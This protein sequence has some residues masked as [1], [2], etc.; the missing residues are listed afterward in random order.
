MGHVRG[1]DGRT[2]PEL[3]PP[4]HEAG[5]VI[6][7][8]VNV[9]TPVPPGPLHLLKPFCDVVMR[10]ASSM[11]PD[12]PGEN[13]RPLHLRPPRDVTL[14]TLGRQQVL[15]PRP[16]RERD[17]RRQ[18]PRRVARRPGHGRRREPSRPN[19]RSALSGWFPSIKRSH[20]DSAFGVGSS[21]SSG[22]SLRVPVVSLATRRRAH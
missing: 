1:A 22:G 4:A 12:H 18:P 14:R 16:G 17:Q 19:C 3:G 9:R 11:R 20:P 2:S 13:M 15:R 6:A 10:P 21:G 8:V 5:R 7:F